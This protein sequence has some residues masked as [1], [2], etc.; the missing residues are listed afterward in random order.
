MFGNGELRI[1]K[2]KVCSFFSL[3]E[4]VRQ[5]DIFGMKSLESFFRKVKTWY[6]FFFFLN[7]PQ[8][9]RKLIIHIAKEI[10]LKKSWPLKNEAL[11]GKEI[12]RGLLDRCPCWLKLKDNCSWIFFFFL[13]PPTSFLLSFSFSFWC[14]DHA[15]FLVL[16]HLDFPRDVAVLKYSWQTRCLFTALRPQWRTRLFEL[17][18]DQYQINYECWTRWPYI[19]SR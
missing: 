6:I 3:K 16:N 13:S 7:F 9:E 17:Q 4:K 2:E 8:E 11:I 1:H 18:K 14:Q 10:S 12:S 15:F 19:H 5:G